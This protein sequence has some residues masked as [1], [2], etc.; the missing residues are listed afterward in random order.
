VL[1]A[2]N[3]GDAPLLNEVA[4][5]AA[6][7]PDKLRRK[8]DLIT[9]SSRDNIVLILASGRKVTW[10]SSADSELKAQVVTALLKRKPTSS[11][12]VSSPHNPAVRA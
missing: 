12:D 5:V 6:S 8:V 7:L 3:A 10:G 9:A 4:G 1:A 2:V 11:I